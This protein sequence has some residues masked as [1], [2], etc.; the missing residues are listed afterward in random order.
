V[1]EHLLDRAIGGVD[2]ILA[3]ELDLAVSNLREQFTSDNL[4]ID[5]GVEDADD[6]PLSADDRAFVQQLQV[7]AANYRVIELAIRDYKRAFLQ[8]SRWLEDQLVDV[9]E[10]SGYEE[11]LIDEW[12]HAFA[13]IADQGHDSDES[14][15]TAGRTLYRD[16]QQRDLWIRERCQQRFIARGSYQM[17]AD[18]LRVGWHPEFVAR[19]R[20]I[21]PVTQ[22]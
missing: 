9:R 2:R 6:V 15:Q 19:L 12:E 3:E 1:V 4:P 5:V 10:L 18:D 7:I 11:R 17:L 21:L 8:R 22:P 13:F 20:A 14:R 16:L